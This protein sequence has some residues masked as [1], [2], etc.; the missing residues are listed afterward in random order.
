MLYRHIFH[1]SC[2]VYVFQMTKYT[3]LTLIGA[4]LCCAC[5]L[6][7]APGNSLLTFLM[8]LGI[9][10]VIF[11]TVWIG[12]TFRTP[13]FKAMLQLALRLAGRFLPKRK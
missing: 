13:E 5:S 1:R 8:R 12:A 6:W 7:L 11:P 2:W 4:A 3:L 10:C 9:V